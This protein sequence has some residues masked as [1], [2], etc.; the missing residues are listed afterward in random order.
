MAKYGAT[1]GE[2]LYGD[3]KKKGKS[4]VTSKGRSAMLADRMHGAGKG[5]LTKRTPASLDA[6]RGV[7]ARLYGTG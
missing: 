7:G 6:K 5:D 1:V 2:R 3:G 4:P